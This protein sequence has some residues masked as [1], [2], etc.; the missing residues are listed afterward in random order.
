MKHLG[1]YILSSFLALAVF[2]FWW[3]LF[4]QALG[5]QEQNQLFLFTWDYLKDCLS[6]SGG[7]ADYIAEF[8]TQFYC[9]R[10]MG[11]LLLAII[12]TCLQ[13]LVWKLSDSSNGRWYSL[14][15]VPS[16][17]LLSDMGDIYV[18]LSFPIALIASLVLCLIYK[19]HSSTL[20]A[21]IA[22]P[23][24]LWLIGPM[25]YI[26]AAYFIY[27]QLKKDRARM[28]AAGA[29][30]LVASIA[31][32]AAIMRQQPL[33]DVLLGREYY[34]IP[35]QI[36][37]WQLIIPMT[38]SLIPFAIKALQSV[39]YN[40]LSDIA[41][42]AVIAGICIVSIPKAYDKGMYE[43]IAYDQLVR[44]EKWEEVLKRAQKYQ[45]ASDIGAVCVNLSLFMS[46]HNVQE[47]ENHFQ[48]GTNCLIMPRVRDLMSNV[49][50]YEV[51]W[52][53][54]FVN[55]ALRYAFDSQESE[56]NNSKSGRHMSK[57]V[58]CHIVNG[59]YKVAEK[60]IDILSQSLFYSKWA[61]S[62]RTYLYN[63]AAVNADPVYGYLR[64]SRFQSDF[65]YNYGEMDKM[66]AI[67]YNQNKNN[68]MAAWYFQAYKM[69]EQ[70][71]SKAT[72]KWEDLH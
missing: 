44:A 35:V 52:R 70:H 27:T 20:F 51:F 69:L 25:M 43:V 50:S 19:K 34:R 59:N 37:A 66:L 58:Q 7:L 23:A 38:A 26:F 17:M 18:M 28:A 11:A 64:A 14:S 16:L 45:P 49:A 3:L 13:L 41:A 63:E 30:A 61:R 36:N 1:R 2:L 57:M 62:Q 72:E 5:F 12:F 67:L 60:Y 54:G 46:G 9:I 29:L 4:P 40:M 71:F 55:S 56:I 65:L 31:A 47:I 68:I 15:F 39:R 53:L 6:Q 33:M 21:L 48:S 10:W 8:I 22:I 24:G 32:S 42:F